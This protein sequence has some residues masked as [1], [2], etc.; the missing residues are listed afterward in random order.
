M[1]YY[2]A[3]KRKDSLTLATTQM[4]L[5]NMM[6]SETSQTP[7]VKHCRIPPTQ[8]P[9]SSQ[10]IEAES[11]TEIFRDGRVTDELVQ[12]FGWR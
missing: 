1:E 2:A 6:I 10:V 12:S 7:K 5:G 11:R 4:D 9:E 3:M 8:G